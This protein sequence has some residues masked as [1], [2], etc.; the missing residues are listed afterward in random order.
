MNF[1]RILSPT[2]QKIEKIERFVKPSR[3]RLKKIVTRYS[4]RSTLLKSGKMVLVFY[5]W[6]TWCSGHDSGFH[7]AGKCWQDSYPFNCAFCASNPKVWEK[8]SA[9][10]KFHK[11]RTVNFKIKGGNRYERE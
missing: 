7:P 11:S 9:E 4:D 5:A 2:G 1:Y 3:L 8:K 10:N 6:P